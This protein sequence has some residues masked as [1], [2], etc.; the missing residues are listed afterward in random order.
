MPTPNKNETKLE[1]LQRCM[2]DS[3]AIK[4]YPDQKQRYAV[5]NSFWDQNKKSKS[6]FKDLNKLEIEE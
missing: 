3:E 6:S 5:C 4:D 1:F 2:G